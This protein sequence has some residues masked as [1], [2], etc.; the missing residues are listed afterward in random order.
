MIKRGYNIKRLNEVMYEVAKIEREE[1][2]KDK[3][4]VEKDSQTIFV[5]NWHPSL[6]TIPS[7]LKRHFHLI[8]NDRNLTKIFTTKPSV[9]YRKPKSLRNHL[10]KNDI[11]RA[12]KKPTS[13][14]PCGKC[15]LCKN[16][17][18]STAASITNEEKGIK[19]NIK[20]FGSCRSKEVIYAA[21]CKKHNKIYVGHTG[22]QLNDRF[23]KHRYDI[24][25]R[26]NN[27]ELAN[28]FHENHVDADM[29]VMILQTDVPSE[30]Q[31]EFLEDKWICR[32]QTLQPTGVNIET[33][34]YA[35]DMYSCYGKTIL[36]P[37]K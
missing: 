20:H 32:L 28:H 21:R 35:K 33:H 5:C 37:P 31:R 19:V 36:N 6:N 25:K 2:L 7:I 4:V 1:L 16:Y 24:K 9:A 11:M 14:I 17:S 18:L 13:T 27:S 30:A 23:S 15:K 10:I 29:E 12:E 22:E 8:E 3:L 26:R 34:Q